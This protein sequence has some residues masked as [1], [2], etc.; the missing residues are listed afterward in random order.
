MEKDPVPNEEEIDVSK[1]TIF[2]EYMQSLSSVSQKDLLT[3]K[4]F[5]AL[6]RKKRVYWDK[7][8]VIQPENLKDKKKENLKD[9]D[10]KAQPIIEQKKEDT[11]KECIPLPEGFVWDT[12][13]LHIP[14]C[15]KEVQT[16]LDKNY[17]ESSEGDFRFSYSEEMIKWALTPPGNDK[18]FWIGIRIK[19]SGKLVGFISGVKAEIKTEDVVKKMIEINFLCVDKICRSKNFGP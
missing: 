13:D 12:C 4:H 3:N 6:C 7:Q 17:V 19:G 8:P 1:F 18:D 10:S 2:K 16:F 15:L 5:E 14:E 9:Q 11:P